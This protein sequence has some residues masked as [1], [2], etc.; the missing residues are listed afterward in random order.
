M[1]ANSRGGR[2]YCF[3][4]FL[5]VLHA[6]AIDLLLSDDVAAVLPHTIGAGWRHVCP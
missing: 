4:F 3:S 6:C 1:L 2:L 5:E